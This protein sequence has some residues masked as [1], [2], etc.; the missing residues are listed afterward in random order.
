MG[1]EFDIIPATEEEKSRET[2]PERYVTEL[3]RHKAPSVC[4]YRRFT[5]VITAWSDFRLQSFIRKSNRMDFWI[6][7]RS[8]SCFFFSASASVLQLRRGA[9]DR[10]L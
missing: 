2:I 7:I 4:L 1:L 8:S 3:A 6:K 9:Q 5:G 10:F